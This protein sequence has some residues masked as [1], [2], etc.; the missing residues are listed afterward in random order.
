MATTLQFRRDTTANL[1]SETGAVGELFVDIDK[2]T[3]VVM[4]GSTSGGFPL[5][6]ETTTQ[7]AFNAA[8]TAVN[9]AA[10]ASLYANTGINNAASASL[11]ANNGITL[12]QAA[13][14][15]ANTAVNNAASASLY[16]NTGINNAASASLYAN[17]GIT[18]A[19]AAYDQANTGGGST[20]DF[21]FVANTITL[22]DFTDGV[23]NVTG[24]VG[25]V[26]LVTLDTLTYGV[27]YGTGSG[28]DYDISANFGVSPKR[29]IIRTVGTQITSDDVFALELASKMTTGSL[30]SIVGGEGQ[31]DQS[32][33]PVTAGLVYSATGGASGDPAWIAEIP[34]LERSYG[35]P[36]AEASLAAFSVQ[37][38]E[39]TRV[40]TDFEYTF[41]QTGEFI[42]DS[43]LIG[44]VLIS[45]DIIT[46]LAL[47]SYGVFDPTQTGTLTVNG[48]LDVL[49]TI[50][51]EGIPRQNFL[52]SSVS[53]ITP[54][55]DYDSAVTDGSFLQPNKKY[56]FVP[57][58]GANTVVLP[59]TTT[60]SSGDCI[61]VINVSSDVN[62]SVY[63]NAPATG[64]GADSMTRASYASFE[65]SGTAFTVTAD[66]SVNRYYM[67]IASI[68]MKVTFILQK[69]NVSTLWYVV[70]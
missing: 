50:T 45:D 25:G 28:T 15:Q 41:S 40:A 12:A 3:L 49:G 39:D 55:A 57:G 70:Y 44:D 42:S 7:G 52:N 9:N 37:E 10:S 59:I 68:G 4:D 33:I 20:G 6:R 63:A 60:L 29:L 65:S 14:D 62:L 66:A 67:P 22:P 38:Y 64:V 16:A 43:A 51:N 27:D 54:S 24:N 48:D 36:Y 30:L 11:Y 34:T 31:P 19:Q 23:L 5:A 53:G 18:L 35:G 1:A 13:Y 17:N 26:A 32:L 56:I 2:D 47:D 8:N 21:T 61:E 46:P 58:A 69:T